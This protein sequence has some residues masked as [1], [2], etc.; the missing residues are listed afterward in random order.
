[1]GYDIRSFGYDNKVIWSADAKKI[2]KLKNKIRLRRLAYENLVIST[3]QAA[4]TGL[5]TGIFEKF[6]SSFLE[7]IKFQQ[8]YFVLERLYFLKIGHRLGFHDLLNVYFSGL[9]ERLT[10]ALDKFDQT[11]QLPESTANFFKKMDQL[12]YPEKE[13]HNFFHQSRMMI[14]TALTLVYGKYGYFATKEEDFLEYLAGCSAIKSGK[15]II[16]IDDFITAYKTYYKLLKTDVTQYKCQKELFYGEKE[17]KGYMVCE[18][19]GGY[20]KLQPGESPDDFSDTCE[21]GGELEFK[22]LLME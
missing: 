21:C 9:D 4:I 22:R 5:I 2:K 10:F 13:P 15:N 12:N 6:H 7:Y 20:Y 17:N 14:R 1:L 18:K 8:I 19:C 16:V 3:S 11:V